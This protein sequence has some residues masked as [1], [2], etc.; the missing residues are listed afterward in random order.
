MANFTMCQPLDVAV[1]FDP[2]WPSLHAH[3][4]LL[5]VSEV[6]LG[7]QHSKCCVHAP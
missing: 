2:M 4:G 3:A 5:D 7:R 6:V 1:S